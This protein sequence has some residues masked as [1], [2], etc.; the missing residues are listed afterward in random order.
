MAKKKLILSQEQIERICEGEDFVY[1]N[2]LASKPDMGDIYTTEVT[3]DGSLE[4]AYADPTTTDDFASTTT[5]NW[6]G[7]AKLAGMGPIV[8]HE[9][10]KKEWI[11]K[12]L[13]QE[14]SEHGNARLMG[15]KFGGKDGSQGKS[16]DATKMA[17]SRKNK[18]EEKLNSTNPQIKAQGAETLRKM[19]NNWDGLDVA[20]SQYS[21]AKAAD[22]ITQS[23]KPDGTKIKSAPKISGN[24]KAHTPKNGV[25][26]N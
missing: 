3:T 18:A 13:M 6:R 1:L 9:M 8:V 23:N 16:Y 25:F 4:D 24:G 11:Q 22:K 21:A 15:Q 14:E 26:L 19:H 2:N 10:S 12:R 20:D 17:I 7:N 5:N